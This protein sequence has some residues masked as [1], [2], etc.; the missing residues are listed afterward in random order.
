[1]AN[2][3][4]AS[5]HKATSRKTNVRR[6]KATTLGRDPLVRVTPGRV[7]SILREQREMTVGQ[8]AKASGLAAKEIRTME[9]KN[10][11]GRLG[12]M[13]VAKALG[14]NPVVIMFPD[15]DHG[16]EDE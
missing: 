9:S 12:C 6:R 4:R 1:M 3:R 5:T 11:V 2:A 15:F 8:L 7:I 10:R 13:A 14:I 16:D